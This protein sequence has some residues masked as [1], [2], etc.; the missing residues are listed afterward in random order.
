M[1]CIF[2]NLA[3]FS[4]CVF[5]W[6]INLLC[7]NYY[8]IFWCLLWARF[9]W[10]FVFK[11]IFLKDMWDLNLAIFTHSLVTTTKLLYHSLFCN[12]IEFWLPI[13]LQEQVESYKALNNGSFE[14][15]SFCFS[16]RRTIQVFS[17]WGKGRS[18]TTYST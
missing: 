16:L 17:F 9:I 12:K 1:Q 4:N 10:S 7:Y 14:K 2:W 18:I 11:I 8:F 6:H 13:S 15:V 3:L 5:W